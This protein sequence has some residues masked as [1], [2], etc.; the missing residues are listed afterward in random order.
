[1]F[2]VAEISASHHGSYEIAKK[3]VDIA[4]DAGVN[5]V[6]FQC[7]NPEQ[8]AIPGYKIKSGA[9]KGR[10]LLE[11]YREAET[12]RDWLPSLFEYAEKKKLVAFASPFHKDDVTFLESINCPIY[13]IASFEITDLELISLVAST[14]KPVL[15]S[16]GCADREHIDRAVE[17]GGDRLTLL[18][19][20]SEYPTSLADVNLATMLELKKY[21]C[22][23]GL[24]D[25][26]QGSVSAI[27]AA[28]LGASII[29]KHIKFDDIGLDSGFALDSSA[30]SDFVRD[31][32]Q[33]SSVMGRVKFRG[34]SELS[35]SAHL[36]PMKP[37]EIVTR[38]DFTI[39]RPNSGISPALIGS[40]IGKPV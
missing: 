21:N 24:S 18:H 3:L 7:F 23:V 32:R 5:A 14:G 35:R 40:M 8:M 4:A 13:K 31:V 37:G 36:R 39:K 20:V 19:C 10:D 17:A 38:R 2:I 33:V 1:M 11:L 29:E 22:P 28:A 6:K 30:L 15:I 12:P 34:L 27:V 16:T 25:H 26:S 9:W